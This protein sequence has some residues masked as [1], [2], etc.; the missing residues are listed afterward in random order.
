MTDSEHL[1]DNHEEDESQT[2]NLSADQSGDPSAPESSCPADNSP[3]RSAET[4]NLADVE[5][6][7]GAR[8]TSEEV[9]PESQSQPGRSGADTGDAQ[10]ILQTVSL[11]GAEYSSPFAAGGDSAEDDSELSTTDLS[12]SASTPSSSLDENQ[13]QQFAPPDDH[14]ESMDTALEFLKQPESMAIAD[15]MSTDQLS[16]QEND[17]DPNATTVL[18]DADASRTVELSTVAADSES[19]DAL[20]TIVGK[21]SDHQLPASGELISG[22]VSGQDADKKGLS[23]RCHTFSGIPTSNTPT[24]PQALNPPPLFVQKALQ[25]GEKQPEYRFKK[26]L[27]QGGMGVVYSC[28][29]TSLD[30]TLAV[31]TLNPRKQGTQ[32]ANPSGAFTAEAII[33]ANLVHPNIVPIHDLGCDSDGQLFYSMKQVEGKSWNTCMAKKSLD[34]NLDIL[35]K[36]CD[37]V[38]YAH[39]R[40]VINRDL[41][42][43]NVAIGEYGEVVVLDWG[44]AILTKRAEKREWLQVNKMGGSGTPAYMAPELA[45]P[46]ISKVTERSDIY[47]LGAM[48]FEILEGFAPH[49]LKAF[50]SI[51]DA[52]SR[53]D[54]VVKAVVQNLIEP[55]VT[56]KGE[57]MDIAMC[58]M[59]TNPEDR[60]ESVVK[61]QDAIREYRITGRAEE[62]LTRATS[63]KSEGYAEFQASVALFSEALERRP[64]NPRALRGDIEARKAF[65]TVALQR[66]DYD[67]GL[68]V[69]ADAFSEDKD[70]N[71]LDSRLRNARR[72]RGVIK[73]TWMVTLAASVVFALLSAR[74]AQEATENMQLAQINEQKAES[75]FQQLQTATGTLEQVRENLKVSEAAETRARENEAAAKT[76]IALA[77]AKLNDTND[78]LESRNRELQDQEVKLV[79]LNTQV[80]EEQKKAA[81]EQ[82]KALKAQADARQAQDDAVTALAEAVK[83]K[84]AEEKARLATIRANDEKAKAELAA[85]NAQTAATKAQELAKKT[86]EDLTA[87]EKDL[88]L[89][90]TN[91]KEADAGRKEAETARSAAE[92][93]LALRK[94]EI[95]RSEVEQFQQLIQTQLLLRQYSEVIATGQQALRQ[96]EDNPELTD[97]ERTAI[98]RQLQRAR[99]NQGH[100]QIRLPDS[101]SVAAVGGGGRLT[102]RVSNPE[103]GD[104][105]AVVEVLRTTAA[106]DQPQVPQQ[107]A[108][109]PSIQLRQISIS[110]SGRTIC[111]YGTGAAL[112]TTSDQQN[113]LPV[114][115]SHLTE[116]LAISTAGIRKCLFSG[117]DSRVYLLADDADCTLIVLDISTQQPTLLLRQTLYPE[118]TANFRCQDA[119]L[120]PDEKW[121]IFAARRQ[122]TQ[123]RAFRLVKSDNGLQLDAR[124]FQAVTIQSIGHPEVIQLAARSR[125]SALHLSQDGSHLAL[126]LETEGTS[127]LLVLNAR[128]DGDENQFP[129]EGPAAGQP[130]NRVFSATGE[131]PNPV[132]F[133][134][135]GRMLA[136]GLQSTRND[137]QLWQF[138][139][140]GLLVSAD[141]SASTGLWSPVTADQESPGRAPTLLSG[142]SGLLLSL[143]FSST[144]PE[145]L[146]AVSR[147]ANENLIGTWNLSKLSGWQGEL[148]QLRER[149]EEPL[150]RF[151]KASEE[152]PQRESASVTR[153]PG[154]SSRL[155]LQFTA[156]YQ[157]CRQPMEP[158]TPLMPAGVRRLAPTN[159]R[160]KALYSA[161]FS[162][163]GSRVLVGADDLAA[164][165]FDSTS[166]APLL[167][168]SGRPS[169]LQ[170]DSGHDSPSLF[171]EGHTSEVSACQ[172][173][174]RDGEILLSSE[175]FGVISVWDAALDADGAGREIGRLLTGVSSADFAVSADQ[176]WVLAAGARINKDASSG[177]QAPLLYDGMIWNTADLMNQLTPAP[178]ITLSG[179]HLGA[180]ITSVAISPDTSL[181]MTAGRRGEINLWST[182]SGKHLSVVQ[183]AHDGDGVSGAFFTSESEFITAGYDGRVIRWKQD[184]DVLRPETLFQGE[185]I[186]RMA[187]SP[188]RRRMSIVQIRTED[189]RNFL[190]VIVLKT[191]GTTEATLL[192]RQFLAE[193]RRSPMQTACCWSAPES[194]QL[195]L[196]HGGR[197]NIFDTE[198]WK[199]TGERAPFANG[200]PATSDLKPIRAAFQ[201]TSTGDVRVATL[202]GR[203]LQLWDWK[204]GKHLCSLR[205]HHQ[206][207]TL[208]SI[209]ADNRFVL[210]G[211]ET[212]R[213]FEAGSASPRSGQTI[214]RIPQRDSHTAPISAVSFSPRSGDYR[215]ATA[216]TNGEVRIWQW[217]GSDLPPPPLV[218]PFDDREAVPG[219][220]N[221]EL[222]K[223]F[224]SSV[225]WSPDADRLAALQNGLAHYWDLRHECPRRYD[226]PLPEEFTEDTIR[227]S[228]IN[229]AAQDNLLI[230][231][232]ICQS[233]SEGLAAVVCL[234]RID[235]H[236]HLLHTLIDRTHHS[237]QSTDAGLPG[238]ITAAD[239]SPERSML[240]TGGVDGRINEWVLD[241]ANPD[242]EQAAAWVS[243]L[244]TAGQQNHLN[245]LLR[246]AFGRNG[247]ILTADASGICLIWDLEVP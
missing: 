32:G 142:Q 60:Y 46:E 22:P 234:W 180:E 160:W 233:E 88:A 126:G 53:F 185:M 137:I 107:L 39:S 122:D 162:T 219:W 208:A 86:Q 240:L 220:A 50:G 132:C 20:M 28:I 140:Q 215:F 195:L 93:Q 197:L 189:E 75:N 144:H 138:D 30:R 80:V 236:A 56:H 37:A 224:V 2:V 7:P 235:E 245:R 149:F 106:A 112:W 85:A 202:G 99:S 171:F 176:Q 49:M 207:Q 223:R 225:A 87:K 127:S 153:E 231:G 51:G 41:K 45:D 168:A 116:Q 3:Q 43:E 193:D 76:E 204:S 161:E 183:G 150:Q 187:A 91:L 196:V 103:T 64:D 23:L 113:Y 25:R 52:R 69:L 241:S 105:P 98:E 172:F 118:G 67:L 173:V 94:A 42:P 35:L 146:V 133:S 8:D 136:G 19:A 158:A 210:T 214:I 78:Q 131:L 123:C 201:S 6:T 244:E 47:L 229:F 163:D 108:F 209:S 206:Q 186:I 175:N 125:V 170:A 145:S 44:L 232:G 97:T 152:P 21:L 143:T 5:Q 121:L 89:A 48:L 66:G 114:D 198:S 15:P 68:E 1:D 4:I 12:S 213:V 83:A 71:S 148:E 84:D 77:V 24:L 247:Q 14:E 177:S 124:G 174:G 181:A 92:M 96:L 216:D 218:I 221:T 18:I 11:M 13:T 190:E 129:F 120:T 38:A 31:K 211:S 169:L 29:Q 167:T 217:S 134:A 200:N 57:L 40:G 199:K 109:D 212:I 182:Q 61:F 36:V 34:E 155:A 110:E 117:D 79:A 33:T 62:L 205:S 192:S 16:G 95:N 82:Q 188:D 128:R 81:A 243:R 73:T 54:S 246:I 151:R 237:T 178:R 156:G 101:S 72:I 139:T 227:F 239:F 130:L 119:V 147:R 194:R 9:T 230:A 165:V 159:A 27:G 164:H 242:P 222:I 100:A 74:N 70:L 104:A 135:D 203:Q 179:Q 63:E 157:L 111:G 228:T 154:D 166:A 59:S 26:V 141:A 115:L 226:L 90:T 58:A 17:G 102:V 55:D 184:R 10:D 191:D 238:G 65:S